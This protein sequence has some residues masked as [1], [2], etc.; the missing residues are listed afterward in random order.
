[1]TYII[2]WRCLKTWL[3]ACQLCVWQ[4]DRQTSQSIVP[5]PNL[6]WCQVG[7]TAVSITWWAFIFCLL[8]IWFGMGWERAMKLY[9]TCQKPYDSCIWLLLRYTGTKEKQWIY[10]H[11]KQCAMHYCKNS[12]T[13]IYYSDDWWIKLC[14]CRLWWCYCTLP[15]KLSGVCCQQFKLQ[16]KW[17]VQ[18]LSWHLANSTHFC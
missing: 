3:R 17:L 11:I 13:H 14:Q 6:M 7:S 8:A 1:M 9:A 10:S 4:I 5:P 2:P 15:M 16:W 12:V 18:R